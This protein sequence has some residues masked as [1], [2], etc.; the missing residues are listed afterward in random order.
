MRVYTPADP[1]MDENGNWIEPNKERLQR[2]EDA[3]KK[4]PPPPCEFDCKKRWMCTPGTMSCKQFGAY[5]NDEPWEHLSRV[6][7]ERNY[8]RQHR[9]TD[10]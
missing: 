4:Q 9:D 3:A 7:T 6:P 5:L 1:T 10:V 2:I 8:N